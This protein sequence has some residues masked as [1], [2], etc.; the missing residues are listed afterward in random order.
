MGVLGVLNLASVG[1]GLIAWILPG[2]SILL[3]KKISKNGAIVLSMISFTCCII[4]LCLQFF[5]IGY[6]VEA[7]DWTALLDTWKAVANAAVILSVITVVSNTA[8]LG[9]YNKKEKTQIFI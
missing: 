6:R 1:L 2:V 3:Y 8:V 7:S 5:E 4:S 9:A